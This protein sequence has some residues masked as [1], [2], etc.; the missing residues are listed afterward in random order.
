MYVDCAAD[1]IP[2]CMP[3]LLSPNRN[4]C[5]GEADRRVAEMRILYA[6]MSSVYEYEFY[7]G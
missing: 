1:Q 4:F 3:A 6:A 5:A 7:S 2:L